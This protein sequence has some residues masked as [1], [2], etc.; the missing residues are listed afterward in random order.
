MRRSRLRVV[1]IN[2]QRSDPWLRNRVSSPVANGGFIDTGI[3]A[4]CLI[5]KGLDNLAQELNYQINQYLSK[6]W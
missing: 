6:A 1:D 4:L 5:I 3:S 2:S